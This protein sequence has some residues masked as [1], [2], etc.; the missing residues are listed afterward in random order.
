MEKNTR[1]RVGG[2]ERASEKAL[3]TTNIYVVLIFYVPVPS[4]LI[5]HVVFST[6]DR[7][8]FLHSEE[9]RIETCAYMAGILKNLQCHPIKIGGVD[10]HVHI[11]SSLSKNIAFAEFSYQEELRELLKRHRVAFD[12]R[13]LWE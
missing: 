6:K 9:I 7:R 2:A 12:E 3:T 8:P 11:L 10:D 13:Y 5:V 1:A 4:H